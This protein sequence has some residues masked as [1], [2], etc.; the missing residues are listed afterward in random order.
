MT[1][2]DAMAVGCVGDD[3][4]DVTLLIEFEDEDGEIQDPGFEL[5]ESQAVYLQKKL[6]ERDL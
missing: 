6:N 1:L 3:L 5:S 2:L 4:G